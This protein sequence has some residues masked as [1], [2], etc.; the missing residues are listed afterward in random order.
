MKIGICL[1]NAEI[2]PELEDV[3][4]YFRLPGIGLVE[5][6]LLVVRAI[7]A[8]AQVDAGPF[9]LVF[10]GGTALARAHK[11]I[12]RM[13]EDVDF[14]IVLTGVSLSRNALRQELGALRGRVTA[15]LLAAGFVF[16][17]ADAAVVRSRN[18]NRYT[19]YQLP[20]TSSEDLEGLRPTVQI[21]L[22]YA[23][24]RLPPVTKPVASFVHEAFGRDPEVPGIPCVSLDETAAE[25]LVSLTR[26]TAMERAGLSRDV[27]TALVRMSTTCISCVT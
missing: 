21:E 7:G 17:P 8:I 2:R 25:K 3:R 19:I 5:K 11:V 13:S 1:S 18:E 20:Y 4:A 14:K 12:R 10:G 23:A 27:D 24:L 22:T 15:S 16:D 26:R 6:D 9:S